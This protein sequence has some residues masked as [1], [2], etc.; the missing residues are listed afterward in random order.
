MLRKPT[1][2]F[3]CSSIACLGRLARSTCARQ[4][5]TLPRDDCGLNNERYN[6]WLVKAV[7]IF[8]YGVVKSR[9]I[10]LVRHFPFTIT[11]FW[12]VRSMQG[13]LFPEWSVLPWGIW[14]QW[15]Y[16]AYWYK[17][18]KYIVMNWGFH[19]LQRVYCSEGSI[20]MWVLSHY[21]HSDV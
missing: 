4:M 8:A 3:W 9:T 7:Y 10:E 6:S 21:S 2:N 19:P 5:V 14:F 1:S 20:P 15:G 13:T 12:D 16:R 11:I 17:C 18:A